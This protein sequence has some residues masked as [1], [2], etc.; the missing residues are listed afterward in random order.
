MNSLGWLIIIWM[1][2]AYVNSSLG[3]HIPTLW[4]RLDCSVVGCNLVDQSGSSGRVIICENFGSGMVSPHF[5]GHSS[6]D[7]LSPLICMLAW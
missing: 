1:L 2:G 5:D 4:I 7:D 6:T 3:E